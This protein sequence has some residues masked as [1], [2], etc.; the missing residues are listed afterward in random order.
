[1]FTI[2]QLNNVTQLGQYEGNILDTL[3]FST[4]EVQEKPQYL[5]IFKSTGPDMLHPLILSALQDKL[6]RHLTH[7]FNNS[8]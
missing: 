4:E 2:E 5:N 1:M 3:N 7:I 6:S 8:V